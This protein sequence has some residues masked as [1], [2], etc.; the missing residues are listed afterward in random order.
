MLPAA[1]SMQGI[2]QRCMDFVTGTLQL[3][4]A[5]PG[6]LFMTSKAVPP[7]ANRF[8]VA[9]ARHGNGG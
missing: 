1:K 9:P 3:P 5:A 4:V 2:I 8:Q 6:P 7:S